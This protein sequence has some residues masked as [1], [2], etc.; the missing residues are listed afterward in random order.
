MSRSTQTTVPDM[1]ERE[2]LPAPPPDTAHDVLRDLVYA[3]PRCWHRDLESGAMCTEP[4]TRGSWCD[5]HAPP[6]VH[7]SRTARAIR[8]AREFLGEGK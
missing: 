6:N 8:R 7:D 2:T 3:L 5:E 1:G 4:V